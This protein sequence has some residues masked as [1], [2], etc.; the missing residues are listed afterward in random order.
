M[1]RRLHHDEALDLVEAFDEREPLVPAHETDA[2]ERP[3]GQTN[4]G[5]GRCPRVFVDGAPAGMVF[6]MARWHTKAGK[7]RPM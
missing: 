3:N 4:R 7:V 6:L 5:S 1:R 2:V